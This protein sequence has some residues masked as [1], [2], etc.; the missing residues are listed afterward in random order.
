MM[1]PI[2]YDAELP[3]LSIGSTLLS[4]KPSPVDAWQWLM[5]KQISMESRCRKAALG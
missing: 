4:S 3:K 2:R 1:M 5:G